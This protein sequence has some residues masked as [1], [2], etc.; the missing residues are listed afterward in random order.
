VLGLIA[1]ALFESLLEV[2]LGE[3]IAFIARRTT[4]RQRKLN[5]LGPVYAT[6]VY[7]LIG[8]AAGELSVLV[9][10]HRLF[11]P[12]RLPGISL[13]LSP[14]ATGLVMSQA[15]RAG[16]RRGRQTASI[17]SFGYGYTF[18]LAFA[19]VRFLFVN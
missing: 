12:S 13:L 19:L 9:F 4:R 8:A 1:E 15:G 17:E 11:H 3:S 14:L 18:A 7:A 10:H 2:I 6:A 5:R 16:R